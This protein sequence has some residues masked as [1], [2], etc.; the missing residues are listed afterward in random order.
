M[1][2]YMSSK[3]KRCTCSLVLTH[4]KNR[5][6]R[7]L[8]GTGAQFSGAVGQELSEHT[9]PGRMGRHWAWTLST[10]ETR[11]DS[12][13]IHKEKL[14][15]TTLLMQTVS[16]WQEVKIWWRHSGCLVM[17]GAVFQ[18]PWLLKETEKLTDDKMVPVPA[19]C[20]VLEEASPVWT[21]NPAWALAARCH[22]R[23]QN[24]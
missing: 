13:K 10:E 7:V 24:L 15:S 1:H 18:V 9:P 19:E 4:R 14:T 22:S 12:L 17:V 5:N 23:V 2:H 8:C 16:L 20:L 6:V 3:L 21:G 11:D